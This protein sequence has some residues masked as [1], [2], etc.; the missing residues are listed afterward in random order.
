VAFLKAAETR[1]LFA[2]PASR[3]Q[4]PRIA[5]AGGRPG[6]S[7]PARSRTTTAPGRPLAASEAGVHGSDRRVDRRTAAEVFREELLA[8]SSPLQGHVDPGE[9]RARFDAPSA[10][11]DD[12]GY[13]LW[14][15]FCLSRWLR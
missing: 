1:R 3:K 5:Q 4:D 8:S 7:A 15:V 11:R 12:K 2:L 13:V 9:L 10:G 6:K 14:T